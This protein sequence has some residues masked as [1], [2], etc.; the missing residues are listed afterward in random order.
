M[1]PHADD[2]QDPA[3]AID[4]ANTDIR[5]VEVNEDID[6]YDRI[7]MED[8]DGAGNSAPHSW[9]DMTRIFLMN[10]WLLQ[11]ERSTIPTTVFVNASVP[12]TFS[13]I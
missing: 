2:N 13:P 3:D 5:Y 6:T 7:V 11:G 4:D 10:G 1:A 9:K 12:N 8:I